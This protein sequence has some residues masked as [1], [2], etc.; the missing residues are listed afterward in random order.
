MEAADNKNSNLDELIEEFR[1]IVW[2]KKREK[3]PNGFRRDTK[4]RS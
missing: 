4:P 2:M 1:A 3:L